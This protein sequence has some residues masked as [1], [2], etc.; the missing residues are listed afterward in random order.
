MPCGSASPVS[1]PC[2]SRIGA[3]SLS[4]FLRNT[5]TVESCCVVRNI[6]LRFSSIAI[7]KV[8]CGVC[9]ARFGGMSPSL[10]CANT[11]SV[12]TVSLFGA[13]MSPFVGIEVEPGLEL[14]QRRIARQHALGLA[15]SA[16]AGVFSSRS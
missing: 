5:T 16:S 6:S 3:S 8:P 7:P 1:S 15:A 2:S 14:D 10:P 12:S 11:T 4:A 9:R 13:N